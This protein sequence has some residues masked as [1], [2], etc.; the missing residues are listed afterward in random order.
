MKKKV[1]GTLLL[2]LALAGISIFAYYAS[3]N[4]IAYFDNYS[5]NFRRNISALTQ[6]F[7][8]DVP[9]KVE[10]FL[11][12][13]PTPTEDPEIA[14]ILAGEA[15]PG[16]STPIPGEKPEPAEPSPT[17]IPTP[18]PEKTSLVSS[19]PV[20][21]ENAATAQYVR[22][23]SNVLCAAQTTLSAYNTDGTI[24]WQVPIHAA[25]P[26]LKT[27][28]NY[29]L[30]AEKGGTLVEL[31]NGK[32]QVFSTNT[33]DEIEMAA[34]SSRGDVVLVTKKLYYK[35]SVVVYNK[36]GEEV[37]RWNSG[38]YTI[39]DASISPTDRRLA[40]S[41][42]NTDEGAD[43]RI[44][45][46][47]LDEKESYKT[48]DIKDAIAFD[49]EFYREVLNVYTDTKILGISTGGNIS[50]EY[51]FEGRT[52]M[53][54]TAEAD[55]KK[56]CVF[57]NNNTLELI[58]LS[59]GGRVRSNIKSDAQPDFVDLCG[60]YL[61]YNS[62]R[63]LIFSNGS[64]RSKATYTCTRDIQK[65]YIFDSSH[66]LLVYSSSLEFVKLNRR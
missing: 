49:V 41:L 59:A 2:L 54:Y 46:F 7:H 25:D 9:A 29:I 24:S 15:P 37:Y 42:L 57:D 6:H 4:S 48:I 34:L 16:I 3:G 18:K 51:P 40:V 60:S 39:L 17:P 47:R 55:G 66:V 14:A 21:L 43:S 38:S 65:A 58:I 62:G 63:N 26:I 35:G 52:L 5:T 10:E 23:K 53:R 50:W 36:K 32:N 1:I 28:G 12:A 31:Y 19:V 8:I 11:T 61:A 64:G 22:Y 56:L 13:T 27:A 45:L 20:A 44:H 30:I 33:S